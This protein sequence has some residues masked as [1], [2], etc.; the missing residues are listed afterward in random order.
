MV[1]YGTEKVKDPKE[2]E[3]E[4]S[5]E[6]NHKHPARNPVG[7]SHSWEK[8]SAARAR[9]QRSKNMAGYA[10]G[11]TNEPK[12]DEEEENAAGN[13]KQLARNPVRGVHGR[14]NENAPTSS[15]STL[16]IPRG[17]AGRFTKQA[18]TLPAERN[19]PSAGKNAQALH[20]VLMG[21]KPMLHNTVGGGNGMG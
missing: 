18:T 20:R 21:G 3:E 9:S 16:G 7:G 12:E 6:G 15:P 10:T 13:H 2:K 17:A 8:E 5:T 4:E 19:T 14:E 1:G 11:M